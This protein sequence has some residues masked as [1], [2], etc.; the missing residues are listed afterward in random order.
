MQKHQRP[1]EA[2]AYCAAVQAAILSGDGNEKVQDLLILLD[3]TPLSLGLETAGEVMTV[4]IPRNT[5]IPTKKEQVFSTLSDIINLVFWFRF[6]KVRELIRTRWDNNLLGKIWA[7][8]SGIPPAPRGVP[9]ITL[10]FDIDANGILNVSAEDKTTGQ[11]NK[12][13]IT[14]NKARFSKE[15]RRRFRTQRSISLK[16]EEH[17]KK[18]EAKNA[19]ENYAYNMRNTIKDEKIASNLP[20]ADKKKIENAI[21]QVI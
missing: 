3:V 4:L 16:A 10:C 15:E 2:V 13:T 20:H 9:Q 17:K 6:L 12:I 21:E 14:N 11:N 1:D 18:V 8:I 7:L 5:I 19:L